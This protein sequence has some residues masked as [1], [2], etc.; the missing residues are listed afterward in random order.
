MIEIPVAC[1][2]H[3]AM[4]GSGLLALRSIIAVV[5]ML[6]S[7]R[8]MGGMSTPIPVPVIV[9]PLVVDAV[10]SAGVAAILLY[11]A[12]R[13]GSGVR[14]VLVARVVLFGMAI[15][16]LALLICEPALWAIWSIPAPDDEAEM[17]VGFNAIAWIVY[18]VCLIAF[19]AALGT[20][21]GKCGMTMRSLEKV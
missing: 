1:L 4:L 19:Y 15:R 14:L 2:R 3:V 7:I 16:Q 10:I 20:Y 12:L 6:G 13:L 18:Q 5:G 8:A 11:G 17:G 21:A 9:I